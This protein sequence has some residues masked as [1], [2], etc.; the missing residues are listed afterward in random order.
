LG[1]LSALRKGKSGR[2]IKKSNL[3]APFVTPVTHFVT[4]LHSEGTVC[5]A[6]DELWSSPIFCAGRTYRPCPRALSALSG[7]AR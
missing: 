6:T 7:S 1:A 2:Q 4:P 3:F 5:P